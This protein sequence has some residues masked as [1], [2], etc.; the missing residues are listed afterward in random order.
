MHK[1]NEILPDWESGFRPNYGCSSALSKVTD[2]LL[3]AFD[4]NKLGTLVLLDFTKAFD[5][6]NHDMLFS[7]IHYS[8]QSITMS[9]A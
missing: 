9:K 2:D 3:S 5:T 1:W 6:I 8:K 4:N 7:L